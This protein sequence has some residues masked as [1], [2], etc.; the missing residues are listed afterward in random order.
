MRRAYRVGCVLYLLGEGQLADQVANRRYPVW[1]VALLSFTLATGSMV[2]KGESHRLNAKDTISG[3][4]KAD[5]LS[6]G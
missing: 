5:F 6:E 4:K 1:L 3:I 2:A